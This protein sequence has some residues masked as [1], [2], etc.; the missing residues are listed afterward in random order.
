MKWLYASIIVGLVLISAFTV[1][2]TANNI[3]V[4][5]EKTGQISNVTIYQT[6]RRGGNCTGLDPFQDNGV[7]YLDIVEMAKAQRQYRFIS[8]KLY[9]IYGINWVSGST[10]ESFS[11]KFQPNGYSIMLTAHWSSGSSSG[12]DTIWSI[13]SLDEASIY[14]LTFSWDYK[15]YSGNGFV[16]SVIGSNIY[17]LWKTTDTS[18]LYSPK[19][20]KDQDVQLWVLFSNGTFKQLSLDNV[21]IMFDGSVPNVKWSWTFN[22]GSLFPPGTG[23]SGLYVVIPASADPHHSS[24]LE[25]TING[26]QYIVVCKV[27]FTS[28]YTVSQDDVLVLNWITTLS[29]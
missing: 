15:S 22:L 12:D 17:I 2:G 14:K 4:D 28:G 10:T 9:D 21:S 13:V 27:I 25:E 19:L 23:L 24:D 8:V 7:K 29:G 5:I 18:S 16:D 1:M 26:N 11:V 3:G 20:I 6:V